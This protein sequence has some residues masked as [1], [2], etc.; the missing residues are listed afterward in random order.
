VQ[1]VVP[2]L[3]VVPHD[4]PAVH[5]TQLPVG[6]QTWLVPQVEPA[7][8]SF[9]PVHVGVPALQSNVPGLHSEPQVAPIVQATQA[10]APSQTWAP[11]HDVP[12]AAFFWSQTWT[13]VLQSY[14][15]GLHVVPQVPPAVQATQAPLPSQ[16]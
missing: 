2:G 11:P 10:P 14:L 3:Q 16:T 15:P 4:A 5:A 9:C 13:P 12:A 1:L 6:S 8:F 7:A